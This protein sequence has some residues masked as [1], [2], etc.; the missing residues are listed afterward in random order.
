MIT[1]EATCAQCQKVFQRR[2]KDYRRT[3][4]RGGKHFC[5][6]LCS[7]RWAR[8]NMPHSTGGTKNFHGKRKY[9][10]ADEPSPFRFF[11]K[12][13]KANSE[14][15]VAHTEVTISPEYL[16]SV[17]ESQKGRCPFTGWELYLP[18]S[19]MKWPNCPRQRRAS[20]DRIDNSKGYIPGNVRFVCM[21]INFAKNS[22]NDSEL[23]EFLDA[24]TSRRKK[25]E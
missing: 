7:L 20:L 24:I 1:V 17:W 25:S 15:R 2:K 21:M 5:G 10:K 14:I 19:T 13:A 12:V 18:I 6:R 11:Q 3:E 8:E 9:Q 22:F 4:L 23:E 16:K